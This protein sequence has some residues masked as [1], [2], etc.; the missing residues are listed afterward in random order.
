MKIG[1]QKR[2]RIH[3][4]DDRRSVELLAGHELRAIEDRTVDACFR[5]LEC[6]A[7]TPDRRERAAPV[8][9]RMLSE[10]EFGSGHRSSQ[11]ECNDFHLLRRLVVSVETL[12]RGI[13]NLPYRIRCDFAL[14]IQRDTNGQL[15]ILADV[16]RLDRAVEC[17]A[18]RRQSA[19][20]NDLHGASFERIENI[21]HLLAQAGCAFSEDAGLADIDLC[22]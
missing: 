7:T 14:F 22:I 3:L 16:P 15:E 4:F 1:W 8:A 17:H 6:D 10:I 11:S 19:S 20:S 2:C 12:V 9:A 5:G 13:E 21:A 18:R